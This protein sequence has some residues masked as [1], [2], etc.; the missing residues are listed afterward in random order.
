METLIR[1]IRVNGQIVDSRSDLGTG[2]LRTIVE[3]IEN[4]IYEH[5]YKMPDINVY[6]RKEPDK[7]IVEV[8]WEK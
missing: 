8:K 6:D 1:M 3:D 5:C 7:F 4:V 2:V